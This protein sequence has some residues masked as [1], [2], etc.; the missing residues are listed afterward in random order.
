MDQ[1]LEAAGFE[2][3][4]TSEVEAYP[5]ALIAYHKPGVPNL[6]DVTKINWDEVPTVDAICAEYVGACILLHAERS[7]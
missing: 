3:A 1:G 5:C 7:K 2:T 4:W 6:G